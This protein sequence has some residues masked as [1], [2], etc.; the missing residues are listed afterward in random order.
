LNTARGDKGKKKSEKKKI[1]LR[2]RRTEPKND[3]QVEEE[4]R[5]SPDE[6]TGKGYG[7]R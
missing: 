6:H 7:M 5:V 3:Q 4:K 1:E 2:K